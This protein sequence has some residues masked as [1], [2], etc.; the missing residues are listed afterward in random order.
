MIGTIV[1]HYT[2]LEKLG[3]G[4][5]GVVYKAL[6]TRL[7]RCI[8]LKFLPHHLTPN[9]DEQARFMQEA[10]AAAALNHPNVCT[11]IDIQE[12]SSQ[13]FIVM[14]YVEGTT[15]RQKS[16]FANIGD[17]ISYAIQIGE[18]LA[19]AHAKG[20]VHRDIKS[21][22][23]ML[24]PDGRIK[25]MDFGLA[26]LKGSLHL[27]KES[28]TLGTLAYM[29]P[30]QIEGGAS[31]ARSD[32][33]SFGVLLFE[34]LTGKLPFR[35]EHDAALM[36]SIINEEPESVHRYLADASPEI[37]RI[38]RRALEKDPTE[39]YQHV[40]D[41]VSELR[42]LQRLSDRVARPT[43]STSHLAPP[44]GKR[45][46]P[47]KTLTIGGGVLI[48][49]VAAAAIFLLSPFSRQG[50]SARERTMI[51][52]LPFESFGAPDKEYFADGISEEITGRLSG[53][54][55]LGVIAYQSSAQYKKTNKSLAEI[56][57]EL[58]IG[59]ILR[60]T[61][62]WETEDGI[63]RI[64]VNPALIKIADGTQVWSQPY[65]SDFSSAFKLQANIAATVAQALNIRLAASEQ[66]KLHGALTENSRAYDIYLSALPYT[67]DIENEQKIRLAAR[68]FQDAIDI[69]PN[70]AAA[71]AELSRMQAGIYW[72]YQERTSETL[73]NAKSN[74]QRA[75]DLAP[76]LAA[77]HVAMGDYHYHGMLAYEPALLEYREALRLEP[78]NV[79]AIG[80]IGFVLRRQGKTREALE[81]LI[82]AMDLD[83]RDY[84]TVFSVAETYTLLRDY[85]SADP[86]LE[87][88]RSLDPESAAPYDF[89][90]RIHLLRD[91]RT[92]LA[93]GS[94]DE[95][96]KRKV[97][98]GDPR[99]AYVLYLCDLCDGNFRSAATRF[100]VA[101]KFDDQ[102]MYLP[103]ELLRAQAAMLAGNG[104]LARKDFDTARQLLEE[105]IKGHPDDPRLHSAFGIALGGLGRKQDALREGRQAVA[106]MPVSQEAWRGSFRLLDL[107]RI[108]T[109]TGDQ[110]HALEIL[111]KLLSQPTDAVSPALLAIDPTWKSLRQ[112]QRFQELTAKHR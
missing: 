30:E 38:L 81:N 78:N 53:L 65:E 105:Q 67:A 12:E 35:G 14:E 99:L 23:V 19:A 8:A 16:P 106:L 95:A 108:Y 71:Y 96:F 68:L 74:A 109:L 57:N 2:I 97:G 60:G 111:D 41:M 58:H 24:T 48:M 21:D 112:H 110:E 11:V 36:Y 4:G 70:F 62:R 89:Q 28:S 43:A 59:Y 54:S 52:V 9:Q 44:Q 40:D 69:D 13:P 101:R 39:R 77:A 103:E 51:A 34:M 92:D 1:S 33:F 75:L 76:Q 56:A 82:K 83:P 84:L 42:R 50:E 102:Y 6:D 86:L 100:A 47:R 27:T 3:E 90:A 7:D 25:V 45:T 104:E 15:L 107:A 37:D 87:Q 93:R 66:K 91:A 98:T 88:A 22:N 46:V 64:R 18:A 10:R 63:M 20:I 31:D 94:V 72:T 49:F 32:I 79:D 29:A 26:K 55:G 73:A 61:V 5:M 80:S 85:D 17:A